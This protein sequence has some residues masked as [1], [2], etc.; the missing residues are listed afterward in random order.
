MPREDRK[1]EVY[2]ADS[3]TSFQLLRLVHDALSSFRDVMF[4]V[5][6]RLSKDQF[7]VNSGPFISRCSHRKL[8]GN[9]HELL[10]MP[11]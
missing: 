11:T 10:Q 5:I 2:L 4:S 8:P 1:A 3:E 6:P 9:F 7:I